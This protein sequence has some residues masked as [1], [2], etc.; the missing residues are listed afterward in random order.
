M[1]APPP[2]ELSTVQLVERL[3]RQ[4][5]DLVKTEIRD[6][7]DEVRTKGT[8]LGVGIGISGVGA[9][10]VFFGTATLVAAAVLGLANAIAAWAAA[11]I[12]AAILVVIGAVVAAIGGRRAQAAVPPAPQHTVESVQ[13]DVAMVKE[14]LR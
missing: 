1:S 4:T 11:L 9:L 8:R 13:Q 6:A 5:T 10:L 7:V 12:V 2:D 3:Q 14:H